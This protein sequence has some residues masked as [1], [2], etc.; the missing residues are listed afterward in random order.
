MNIAQLPTLSES[1][2]ADIA[3]T[4]RNRDV[5]EVGQATESLIVDECRRVGDGEFLDEFVAGTHDD[6]V[7]PWQLHLIR[8]LLCVHILHL[9]EPFTGFPQ[10]FY[11]TLVESHGLSQIADKCFR[12]DTPELDGEIG[13]IGEKMK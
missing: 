8:I 10:V 7:R 9:S 12:T 3:H 11:H 2:G 1:A 4:L 13:E 6:L 5:G